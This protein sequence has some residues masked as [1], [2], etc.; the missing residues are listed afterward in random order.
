MEILRE[1][2]EIQAMNNWRGRSLKLLDLNFSG[3]LLEFLFHKLN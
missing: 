3:M 2:V 1:D